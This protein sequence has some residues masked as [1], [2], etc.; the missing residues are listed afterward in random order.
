MPSPG[1]LPMP[2]SFPFPISCSPVPSE[3]F[4]TVHPREAYLGRGSDKFGSVGL[5]DRYGDDQRMRTGIAKMRC[6]KGKVGGGRQLASGGRK[7]IVTSTAASLSEAFPRRDPA[8]IWAPAEASPNSAPEGDRIAFAAAPATRQ[9]PRRKARGTASSR[10]KPP[11][12]FGHAAHPANGSAHQPPAMAP[13]AASKRSADFHEG[14]IVQQRSLQAQGWLAHR[15]TRQP[16][17][18]ATNQSGSRRTVGVA[19][20]QKVA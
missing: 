15:K 4:L 5:G 20:T 14:T 18:R 13:T 7:R 16:L 10:R 2:W 3:L 1:P 6:G 12:P 17:S 8:A 11:E 19:K 9:V